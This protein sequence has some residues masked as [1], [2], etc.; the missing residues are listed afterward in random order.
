VLRK[1][2]GAKKDEVTEEWRRLRNEE[3]YYLYSLPSTIWVIR[4]RRLRWT[5]YMACM[6]DEMCI[7]VFDGETLGK[8]ATWKRLTEMDLHEVGWGGMDR[9]DLA[10]DRDRWWADD[11]ECSN[12]PLGSIKCLEFLD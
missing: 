2:F 9:I 11:C 1:I 12:E 8:E 3:I 6:G 5:G 10:W 4:S 7:Q